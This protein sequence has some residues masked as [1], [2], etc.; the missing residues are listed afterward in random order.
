MNRALDIRDVLSTTARVLGRSL[1]AFALTA[2]LFC[3]PAV[4]L[5]AW[6][7]MWRLAPSAASIDDTPGAFAYPG[8]PYAYDPPYAVADEDRRR[9]LLALL[10]SGLASALAIAA[11]Q[12]GVLFPVVEELAGRR[13]RA[14]AALGKALS[15]L[16]AAL[17]AV[18]LVACAVLFSASCF[19]V[20]AL[21]VGALFCFAVPAAVIEGLPSFKAVARS[22]DLTR[23]QRGTIVALLGAILVG[24]GALRW[25]ARVLL[26]APGLLDV[27]GASASGPGWPYFVAVGLLAVLEAV[28]VAVVSSVLYARLR[29][30]DGVDAEALAAVFA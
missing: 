11:T 1:P 6:L 23:G 5:E 3:A 17:G 24:F 27:E 10:A 18:T 21:V 25:G 12:A 15:R 20:P 22:V 14:G 19:A 16:P 13:V 26:G 29:Q 28:L 30:R 8:D 9:S 7:I 4:A 2:A